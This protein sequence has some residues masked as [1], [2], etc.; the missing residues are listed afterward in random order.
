MHEWSQETAEKEL[1]ELLEELVRL[2]ESPSPTSP[3]HIRWQIRTVTFLREVFGENSLVYRTFARVS[4]RYSG[5]MMVTWDEAYRPMAAQE[6]YD[7]PVYLEAI[8]KAVGILQAAGDELG[9][10]GVQGVYEGK[11]TGPEASLLL[12]IMNLAE[13]KL[14]KIIRAKPEKEREIQDAFETLLLANDIPHSR[15]KDSIEYSSKT[16]TPDFTVRKADLAVEIKLATTQAHEKSLIA[17]IND[18]I[19][20]YRT[21]YGNILFVVYDCGII[22]DVE[23]FVGSFEA[24]GPVSVRVVKH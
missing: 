1:N 4:W 13:L 23:R 15:E 9:R 5:T 21:K 16:Y 3:D 14:R 6:R 18:D 17:E 22:R 11:D 8:G 2:A 24:N 19:L 12:Q 7:I 10:K 20:A